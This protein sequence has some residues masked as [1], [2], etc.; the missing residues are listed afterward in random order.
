MR[1]TRI[2]KFENMSIQDN[3]I[4]MSRSLVA[5]DSYNKWDVLDGSL[6]FRMKLNDKIWMWKIWFCP[7]QKVE[8]PQNTFALLVRIFLFSHLLT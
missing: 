3:K 2:G 7:L 1:I 5:F 8:K 6:Y 4:F